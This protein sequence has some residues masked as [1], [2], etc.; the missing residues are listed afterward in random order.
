MSAQLM[1]VV[2]REAAA[3]L[4]SR[5]C[6]RVVRPLIATRGGLFCAAAFAREAWLGSTEDLGGFSRGVLKMHRAR[7]SAIKSSIN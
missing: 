4:S 3:S 1:T 5:A 6:L 7:C 2:A